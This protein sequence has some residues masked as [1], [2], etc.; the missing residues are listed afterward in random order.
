MYEASIAFGNETDTDDVTGIPTATGA[1]PDRAAVE[2]AIATL[3]GSIE[4]MPPAYSAK[5]VDGVRAYAAARVGAPLQLR[6]V[7]VD[8]HAW[9]VRAW[10]DEGHLDV[11][12]TCGSGTYIRALARD[13]GRLAGSAAHLTALRRTRSGPYDVGAALPIE[14]LG[15]APPLRSPREAL[16]AM[17]VVTIDAPARTRIARGQAIAAAAPGMDADRSS[18]ALL[19]SDDDGSILAVAERQGTTW[20]PR[21]VLVDD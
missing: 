16:G 20:A 4:Q 19:V 18:R 9:D 3:T 8:V 14:A 5:Q 2:R 6:P 11:T 12:I 1:L 13:L 17:A 15:A 10:R 21:V 7:R